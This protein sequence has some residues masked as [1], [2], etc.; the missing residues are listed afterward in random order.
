MCD[1]ASINEILE[2]QR[3]RL[4]TDGYLNSELFLN[5]LN[6][7]EDKERGAVKIRYVRGPKTRLEVVNRQT[8]IVSDVLSEFRENISAYDVL[9]LSDDDLRSEVRKVFVRLGFASA[10]VTGPSRLTD[11]N[12]DSVVRFYLQNGP[13]VVISDTQFVGEIPR[14]KQEIL[15]R[16]E[17]VPG[18]FKVQFHLL[19]I[20]LLATETGC[21]ASISMKDMRTLGSLILFL[22]LLQ[23]DDL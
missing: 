19:R 3:A 5:Q 15:E 9:S 22:Y 11:A 1:K 7:S 2:R 21:L 8:G 4:L 13:L 18:L 16:M 14:P 20:R 10:V 23:T 17:L 6:F 12:G